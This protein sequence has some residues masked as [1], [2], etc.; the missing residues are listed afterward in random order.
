MVIFITLLVGEVSATTTGYTV[1]PATRESRATD[2]HNS[3]NWSTYLV[4]L[5]ASVMVLAAWIAYDTDFQIGISENAGF[6]PVSGMIGGQPDVTG[7]HIVPKSTLIGALEAVTGESGYDDPGGW[8]ELIDDAMQ[9]HEVV[10]EDSISTQLS[11]LE[12]VIAATPIAERP[13]SKVCLFI[14]DIL[15]AQNGT[16]FVA[17]VDTYNG[18]TAYASYDTYKRC[19]GKE[20]LKI[21]LRVAHVGG[22]QLKIHGLW[23]GVQF[24]NHGQP[25]TIDVVVGDFKVMTCECLLGIPVLHKK[26]AIIDCKA[27]LMDFQDDNGDIQIFGKNRSQIADMAEFKVAA[28]ENRERRLRNAPPVLNGGLESHTKS[29]KSALKTNKA[30]IKTDDDEFAELSDAVAEKSR[31]AL[32]KSYKLSLE[33]CI[34]LIQDGMDC[35]SELGY[36]ELCVWSAV[37][38]RSWPWQT[39]DSVRKVYPVFNDTGFLTALQST[40]HHDVMQTV[41]K[42]L[43][44]LK[45]DYKLI[46]RQLECHTSVR[47]GRRPTTNKT[48]GA[49]ETLADGEI[50]PGPQEPGSPEH[51]AIL[52]YIKYKGQ[53]KLPHRTYQRDHGISRP[54]PSTDEYNPYSKNDFLTF[55]RE[56]TKEA[57]NTGIQPLCQQWYGQVRDIPWLQLGL[58]CVKGGTGSAEAQRRFKDAFDGSDLSTYDSHRRSQ[59]KLTFGAEVSDKSL[60]AME[61]KTEPDHRPE[62]LCKDERLIDDAAP[63]S[64]DEIGRL[65]GG[66]ELVCDDDAGCMTGDEAELA[67]CDIGWK[68]NHQAD[69][70][71]EYWDNDNVTTLLGSI[72]AEDRCAIPVHLALDGCT[73]EL[74]SD[75]RLGDGSVGIALTVHDLKAAKSSMEL[76]E[77]DVLCGVGQAFEVDRRISVEEKDAIIAKYT[78]DMFNKLPHIDKG[79]VDR[80]D[81][82]HETIFEEWTEAALEMKI[83]TP[84]FIIKDTQWDHD[85]ACRIELKDEVSQLPRVDYRRQPMHLLQI[86][87]RMFKVLLQCGFYD[88][89]QVSYSIPAIM[90]P[91]SGA[92]RSTGL[93]PDGTLGEFRV[94]GD[95]TVSN[96]L[97]KDICYPTAHLE[98]SI[99]SINEVAV[100]SYR[101]QRCKV[102]GMRMTIDEDRMERPLLDN[103]PPPKAMVSTVDINKAFHRQR[104]SELGVS[105]DVCS[106]NYRGLGIMRALRC[107]QGP[108]QIPASWCRFVTYLLSTTGM[109]WGAGNQ[110]P[111]D[112]SEEAELRKYIGDKTGDYDSTLCHSFLIVYVDDFLFVSAD[113]DQLRRQMLTLIWWMKKKQLYANPRKSKIGCESVRFLGFCCGFNLLFGDPERVKAMALVP[114]PVTKKEVRRYIGGTAFYS[115]MVD[116]YA[117]LCA[118]MHRCT[119]N[120]VP[121]G[122]IRGHWYLDLEPEDKDFE[123]HWRV[124]S[125]GKK[126][127]KDKALLVSTQTGFEM[128]KSRLC[129][130][131]LM[132]GLCLKARQYWIAGDSSELGFGGVLAVM[133]DDDKLWPV[134]YHSVH[135]NEQGQRRA[136]VAREAFCTAC[137]CHEWRWALLGTEFNFMLITDCQCLESAK[138]KKSINSGF[139][140]RIALK[141][142]EF[143]G[144]RFY[145]REGHAA[146]LHT[147]DMLSRALYEYDGS[148]L[149]DQQG[150]AGP[151]EYRDCPVF[152]VLNGI[153]DPDVLIASL[154]W[155]D[156]AAEETPMEDIEFCAVINDG[157]S[158]FEAICD[159]IGSDMRFDDWIRHDAA[160]LLQLDGDARET[161][162]DGTEVICNVNAELAIAQPRIM[163][164]FLLHTAC[165]KDPAVAA[166]CGLQAGHGG[167]TSRIRAFS[168]YE[169]IGSITEIGINDPTVYIAGLFEE[170]FDYDDL[171]YDDAVVAATSGQ[172]KQKA[173]KPVSK[174]GIPAAAK[175]QRDG[176]VWIAA[177]NDN[178]NKILVALGLWDEQSAERAKLFRLNPHLPAMGGSGANT[179]LKAGTRVNL[180]S[181]ALKQ[182]TPDQARAGEG[183]LS[184]VNEKFEAPKQVT[185]LFSP[186]DYLSCDDP[187]VVDVY[188]RLSGDVSAGQHRDVSNYI[189]TDDGYLMHLDHITNMMATVIPTKAAQDQLVEMFHLEFDN[190]RITVNKC[191]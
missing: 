187:K 126:I 53:D 42:S 180:T 144:M 113:E 190:H 5:M 10:C 74:V 21:D 81:R 186:G 57:S 37:A 141:L 71:V 41:V 115:H 122:D 181:K 147:P 48:V 130:G 51:H 67:S 47:G 169:T 87:V 54:H 131:A 154:C 88:R 24:M 3:D 162:D 89:G 132:T 152:N 191:T 137:L 98:D 163:K 80:V 142:D 86:A 155:A 127:A 124:K 85:H 135:Y 117:G 18:T 49:S 95:S 120:D 106:L 60:K 172:K 146:I 111:M 31:K 83:D 134:A 174:K 59:K 50:R 185:T 139:I 40:K 103:Q 6:P 75:K 20:L 78:S 11:G 4:L 1:T 140:S 91:K 96:S 17:G 33:R 2:E 70:E 63:A 14:T 64:D 153:W 138:K 118:P 66:I 68:L 35:L 36:D 171:S 145:W 128:I 45:S 65:L 119:K 25:M 102:Q 58:T 34:R 151:F 99:A 19:G 22:G 72:S 55:V 39:D 108:K 177:E 38:D 173:K 157:E 28:M 79:H 159:Q 175:G 101:Q 133:G 176:H 12:S 13:K 160:D 125:T 32:T 184:M 165:C 109:L 167:K 158:D 15:M 121:D 136:S 46:L 73:A 112:P 90:I 105:R 43:K 16:E 93:N 56:S 110:E 69:C 143:P 166:I 92:S 44:E 94:V 189:I 129:V 150:Y 188:K 23:A 9:R 116:N 82:C 29:R 156:N 61:V 30:P 26:E 170:H 7:V 182:S 76:L 123:T 97:T 178:F 179:P 77:S 62:D 161:N 52:S 149:P 183:G 84:L 104:L 100:E 148:R 164:D 8:G 168:A 107:S 114:E 27:G